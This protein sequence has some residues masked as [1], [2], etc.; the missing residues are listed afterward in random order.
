MNKRFLPLLLIGAL[1]MI[2]VASSL[3]RV[4]QGSVALLSWRGGG[5]PA[6]LRPGWSFR[7]PFL[8]RVERLSAG[9][10][11]VDK[12]AEVASRAGQPIGLPYRLVV[13]LSEKELLTLHREHDDGVTAALRE[14]IESRLRQAAGSISTHDLASGYALPRLRSWIRSGLEE[15]FGGRGRVTLGAP[16]V[17]DSVRQLFAPEAVHAARRESGQRVLLVGLDGADW[18]LI[19]PMIERGELP[20]FASL[21]RDGA[22][23][24]MRSNVPTLSPL[25]WTTIATG[26]SPDRHGINDFLVADP[27]TGQRVPINSTFRRVK[28]LWSILADAGLASDVIR[29]LLDLRSRRCG[30]R[31]R[32]GLSARLRGGR[33]PAAGR[34]AGD[35]PRA[36][37]PFP[38]HRRGD[39][40]AGPSGRRR[41]VGDRGGGVDQYDGPGPRGDRN[42]PAGGARS[43]PHPSVGRG[44]A[45]AVRRLLPGDRRGQPSLR[46]LRAAA[47]GPLFR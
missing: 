43:P 31:H 10:L 18:D 19:D 35:H 29:R 47:R 22:W 45:A 26:K 25:L 41:R 32:S 16:Q 11:V 13:P 39:L 1:A 37:Q 30:G 42:L 40:P 2:A 4:P 9:G 3:I 34:R 12:T 33:R 5:T 6:L 46:P 8:Q 28:A 14:W 24:R 21:K 15:R 7:V 36:D 38:A 27:R 23:A 20:R 17:P 44:A